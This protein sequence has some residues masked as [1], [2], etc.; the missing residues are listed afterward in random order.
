MAKNLAS[1]QPRARRHH[2]RLSLG[3]RRQ[4]RPSRGRCRRIHHLELGCAVLPLPPAIITRAI[5]TARHCHHPSRRCR[6]ACWCHSWVSLSLGRE[7]RGRKG[8]WERTWGD[9]DQEERRREDKESGQTG[10]LRGPLVIMHF[11]MWLLKWIWGEQ[12][13][14][15]G[16]IMACMQSI[17]VSFVKIDFVIVWNC[18]LLSNWLHY[19]F[20]K[21][22]VIF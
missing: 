8:R 19:M 4:I 18:G 20:S 15:A 16:A 14:H 3:R 22:Y 6:R 17:R 11:R 12:F 13:L 10:H 9:K 2:R 21:K 7:R 5:V 1:H